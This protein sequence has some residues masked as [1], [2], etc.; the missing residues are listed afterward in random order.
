MLSRPF[1]HPLSVYPEGI[2][3]QVRPGIAHTWNLVHVV[4]ELF[5]TRVTFPWTHVF[6]VE[7]YLFIY[8]G[9]S[10]GYTVTTGHY[11]YPIQD[12]AILGW[13]AHTV[14]PL[15]FLVAALLFFAV[16]W[17]S[18][19]LDPSYIQAHA[20]LQEDEPGTEHVAHES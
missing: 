16:K 17:V 20:H 11:I 10:I 12:P 19:V 4:T 7:T 6:F 1:V 3:Y 13:V 5:L 9:F 8:V 15:T 2:L 14:I 18:D